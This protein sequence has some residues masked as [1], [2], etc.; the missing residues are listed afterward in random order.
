VGV[1]CR[2]R[3]DRD[4]AVIVFWVLI[5]E[6]KTL[7]ASSH[8]SLIVQQI[9][10]VIIVAILLTTDWLDMGDSSGKAWRFVVV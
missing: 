2:S 9:Y 8:G 3:G 5:P 7:L 1:Y 6:M 4:Q 10:A